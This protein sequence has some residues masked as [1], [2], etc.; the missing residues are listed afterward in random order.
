MI[1]Y[2]PLPASAGWTGLSAVPAGLDGPELGGTQLN[3]DSVVENLF[4]VPNG[5]N[6]RSP[7]LI[8]VVVGAFNNKNLNTD[9]TDLRGFCMF[10][11][12]ESAKSVSV[13]VL[14]II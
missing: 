6:L 8:S 2:R 10:Q 11:S 1:L 5:T 12:V 9:F 4:P 3:R 7:P 14:A 13:L